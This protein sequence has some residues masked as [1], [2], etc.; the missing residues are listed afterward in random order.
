MGYK[1]EVCVQCMT[2]NHS[3]FIEDAMNGFCSQETKFPYVCVVVDDSSTDGEPDVIRKYLDIHFD[4]NDRSITW[5]GETENYVSIFSRHKTN[6]NCYFSV[7]LLKYNHYQKKSKDPYIQQW[8]DNSK[9]IAMC[10]G[11]DYWTAPFKLQKQVDYMEKHADCCLCCHNAFRLNDNTGKNIGLFRIYNHSRNAKR[12]HLFRDGGFMPL[13]SY[14]MRQSMFGNSFSSFPINKMA[15][16]IRINVFASIVGDVYYMN[17]PMSVYRLNS[18]S[19]THLAMK[20][21]QKAIERQEY[22]INWYKIADEYT[23]CRYHKEFDAS[24]A[25]CE[26]RLLRIKGDYYRLWNPRYWPYLNSLH[27][28]TRLG[29]FGGM[30]GLSFIP[31][32]GEKVKKRLNG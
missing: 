30:L 5:Y 2:Y 13:A 14:L 7:L 24:I 16:D 23:E 26:A 20:D 17:D 19:I 15:G 9:Y 29:L 4:L 22:F 28:T 21:K 1:Y 27:L 18:M 8:T 25:F 12:A 11:D 32:L 31:L 3:R 6:K 10:E